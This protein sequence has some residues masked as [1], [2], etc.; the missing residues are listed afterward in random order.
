M[1]EKYLKGS[2]HGSILAYFLSYILKVCIVMDKPDKNLVFKLLCQERH[3]ASKN[4]PV[5]SLFILI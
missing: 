3:F 1:D 2:S 5:I 4:S